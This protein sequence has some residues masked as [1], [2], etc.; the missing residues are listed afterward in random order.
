MTDPELF[1]YDVRVRER[2][3]N[4]AR[5]AE[6]EVEKHLAG[7]PDLEQQCDIVD[8][9]QPALGTRGAFAP[10]ERTA[11]AVSSYSSD[12]DLEAS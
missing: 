4:R 8:L 9:A 3:L 10:G 6:A 2:M 7:L 12:E 5:I 1:K 11:S